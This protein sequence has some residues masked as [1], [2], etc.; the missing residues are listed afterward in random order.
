MNPIQAEPDH[1]E[2]EAAVSVLRRGGL[3][4]F[5][6]DTVFGLGADAFN[7]QAVLS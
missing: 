3:V 7:E 6:T 2:L 5:P 4:A 1:K